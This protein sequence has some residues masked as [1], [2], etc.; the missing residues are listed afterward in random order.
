M[1][2][3]VLHWGELVL[4][5]P[6]FLDGGTDALFK[7]VEALTVGDLIR[8]FTERLVVLRE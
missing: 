4:P 1:I 2:D 3:M 5:V 8:K 7:T 6:W